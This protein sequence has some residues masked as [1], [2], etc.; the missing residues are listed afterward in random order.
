MSVCIPSY[1]L[2]SG[3]IAGGMNWW[4]AVGTMLLGN[5]I[6]LVPML[7]NGHPGIRYGIPSS[8]LARASFGVRGANVPAVLRAQVA[9]GWLEIQTW[10]GGPWR[11][12][13]AAF[14][15]ASLPSGR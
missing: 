8:V 13:A 1:M 12:S 6:V 5:L 3:L 7:L 14:G 10:I 11:T 15:F 4:Q 2:A 9:C